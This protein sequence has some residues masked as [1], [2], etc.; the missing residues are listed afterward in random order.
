MNLNNSIKNSRI[1]FVSKSN[2]ALYI[3]GSI[4]ILAIIMWCI[5]GVNL[6]IDFT[7]GTVINI[8]S[9]NAIE[10][11]E[12][13]N[14]YIDRVQSVLDDYGI[15][16][17][18]HQKEGEGSSAVLQI[19]YQDVSGKTVDEMSAITEQVVAGLQTEFASESI[20]ISAGDR[21]TASASSKLLTNALLAVI[22]STALILLYIAIRFKFL[23]GI[24]GV[25]GIAHDVLIVFAFVLIFNL[26]IG[27]TFIAALITVIGYSLNNNVVIFDRVRENIKN[28]MTVDNVKVTNKSIRQSLVRTISTTLTTVIALA[29]IAILGVSGIQSFALPI[30]VGIMAGLFSSTFIVTPL[31]ARFANKYNIDT[32]QIEKLKNSNGEIVV[33]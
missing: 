26:Q 28:S 9:G 8:N 1:N 3:S 24:C 2:L 22:I 4:M 13:Y 6:S 11:T 10:T 20:E 21:I 27:S 31:F 15:T 19:R 16:I 12:G 32:K 5:L 7:G 17:A 30:L 14:T 33:E 18:Y 25:I 29:S 23:Y